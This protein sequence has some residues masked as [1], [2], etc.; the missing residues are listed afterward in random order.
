MKNTTMDSSD[1]LVSPEEIAAMKNQQAVKP[2]ARRSEWKIGYI[3][4]PMAVLE[5]L[6]RTNYMPALALAIAVY[7]GWYKDRHHRNPVKLTSALLAKF[8]ISRK[9]KEK[10]LKFLGE[11]GQ[12]LVERFPGR[13][14]LVLMKW[15][16]TK[17]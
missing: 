11:S 9:Q 8:P 1:F 16:L 15:K 7:V 3:P 2:I 4:F 13:N 10:G 14:P 6:I 12:F 17:D 5:A